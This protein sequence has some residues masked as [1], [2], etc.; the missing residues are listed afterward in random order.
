[1]V[2]NP[3]IIEG[4]Y[5]RDILSQPEAISATAAKLEET[6]E[7]RLVSAKLNRGG[8]RSIILT[9]MGGSLHALHPICLDLIHSG[10][11]ASMIETSELIHHQRQLVNA[12]N[13]IIAVSQSGQSAEMVRLLKLN[14]R[15]AT[16]IAVTNTSESPLARAAY[17]TLITQ[18]GSEFSVSCKTYVTALLALKWLASV[19]TQ[20]NLRRVRSELGKS[21][22]PVRAYLE[23]WKIHAESLI[24]ALQGVQSMFLV[25]RG[26][27]LAAVGTGALVIKESDHFHAEGMSSAA[28]RHGPIEMLDNQIFVGVF[29]GTRRTRELNV[30][31]WQEIR[32][33]GGKTELLGE[34]SE[35]TPFR[36]PVAAESIQ[37]IL[38]VLPVQMVTLA[39]AALQGREA[40][41]FTYATKITTTE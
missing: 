8:F 18:A 9:G 27:S 37:P 16:V 1:M 5:L 11:S 7:L 35:F 24:P 6:K 33:R 3:S 32:E 17:A 21:E 10:F 12:K 41:R 30:K 23:H 19:L 13:L 14:R 15:K 36:L 2:S 28:F 31:L 40:G 25:G 38:E 4:P 20:D 34:H 39:L 22:A 29:A 26:S